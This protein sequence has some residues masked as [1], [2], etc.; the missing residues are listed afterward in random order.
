LEQDLLYAEYTENQLL[1]ASYK[2]LE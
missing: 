1:H 2:H